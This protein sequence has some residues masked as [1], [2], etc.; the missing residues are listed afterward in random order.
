MC[1]VIRLLFYNNRTRA[2]QILTGCGLR[3]PVIGVETCWTFNEC[4]VGNCNLIVMFG[5]SVIRYDGMGL[6]VE[7]HI[8]PY[9]FVQYRYDQ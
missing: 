8:L 7:L 4:N 1:P 9:H 6:E 3:A 5:K 2:A